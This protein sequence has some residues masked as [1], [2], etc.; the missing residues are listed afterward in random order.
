MGLDQYLNAKNPNRLSGEA[1]KEIYYWRKQHDL[2]DWMEALYRTKGGVEE[3]FNCVPVELT[4]QDLDELE[5]I[6]KRDLE[7]ITL[8]REAI[9]DGFIVNYDC[10]W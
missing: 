7:A 10:W 9:S 3:S 5:E 8:A 1:V 4:L 6:L 2:H